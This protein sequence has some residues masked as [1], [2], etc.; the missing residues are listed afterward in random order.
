[1]VPDEAAFLK[2]LGLAVK[3]ARRHAQLTQERLSERLGTT[4]EWVSQIERGIGN[5]S[6]TT[7]LRIASA[8]QIPA[9]Q[10]LDVATNA[11]G[12]PGEV[13]RLLTEVQNLPLPAVRVLLE[14]AIALERMERSRGDV[15][16]ATAGGRK[17]GAP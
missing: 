15:G 2:A 1:M 10:L 13:S 6:A 8:L 7:L 17:A 12:K 11:A 3:G 16:E 9:G 4:S 14:T 5:P